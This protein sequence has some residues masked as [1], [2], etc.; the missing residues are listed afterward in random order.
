[1][2][3]EQN[4]HC[5]RLRSGD[6]RWAWSTNEIGNYIRARSLRARR[7]P[8]ENTIGRVDAAAGWRIGRQRKAQLIGP[9]R[10][11]GRQ[12]RYGQSFAGENLLFRE[13]CE[14]TGQI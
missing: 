2:I 11:F 14:D 4:D 13:R 12:V 3:S 9:V 6:G 8:G 10:R 5:E 1:M 7:S